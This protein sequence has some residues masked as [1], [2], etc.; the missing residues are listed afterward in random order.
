MLQLIHDLEI[1]CDLR[2]TGSLDL[3]RFE[4]ELKEMEEYIQIINRQGIIPSFEIEMW[5]KEQVE[6]CLKT[7]IYKGG[8]E[9]H[10]KSI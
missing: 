7:G 5:T 8:L 2:M 6:E 1:D 10:D 9:R 3:A 4:V